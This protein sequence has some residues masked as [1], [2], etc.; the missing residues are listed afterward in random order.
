MPLLHFSLL[1][2][3]LP[4]SAHSGPTTGNLRFTEFFAASTVTSLWKSL[5]PK[6]AA[7]L[8]DHAEGTNIFQLPRSQKPNH[9]LPS[10]ENVKISR[11]ASEGT[12]NEDRSKEVS[13]STFRRKTP[14]SCPGYSFTTRLY[15]WKQHCILAR[16]AM[17]MLSFSKPCLIHLSVTYMMLVR[18]MHCAVL[19]VALRTTATLIVFLLCSHNSFSDSPNSASLVV[20][21][22]RRNS[23]SPLVRSYHLSSCLKQPAFFLTN[24]LDHFSSF[25]TAV[26]TQSPLH[27]NSVASSPECVFPL[28]WFT[29][30][31]F[32]STR[33]GFAF[34]LPLHIKNLPSHLYILLF[35]IDSILEDKVL[36]TH[37][38]LQKRFP[39]Y[40]VCP[41]CLAAPSLRLGTPKEWLSIP[42][43][44]GWGGNDTCRLVT[45]EFPTANWFSIL[46]LFWIIHTIYFIL[47]ILY[48]ARKFQNSVLILD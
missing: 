42:S 31:T 41:K 47:Q 15:Q 45:W 37:L 20:A 29:R 9:T 5:L 36:M 46:K 22:L 8:E 4:S 1:I 24:L 18:A 2:L 19:F 38:D 43:G 16:M 35:S 39:I 10:S 12:G 21:V 6:L 11:Q 30:R 23:V 40:H 17:W 33:L 32:F 48:S 28:R 44:I 26:T 27:C 34:A 14:Q 3:P 25:A 7:F 13:T